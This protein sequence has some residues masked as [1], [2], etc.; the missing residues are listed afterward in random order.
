MIR[1]GAL[2][3][4]AGL[5]PS[6]QRWVSTSTDVRS[7]AL[8]FS[9][10]LRA[11]FLPK[12]SKMIYEDPETFEYESSSLLGDGVQ[13]IDFIA[14]PYDTQVGVIV[15]DVSVFVVFRGSDSAIDAVQNVK[16]SF[17]SSE[18][19]GYPVNVHSGFLENFGGVEGQ[20][21]KYVDGADGRQVYFAGHSLGGALAQI[22]ALGLGSSRVNTY[23]FGA[24]PV[25][26]QTWVDAMSSSGTGNR[27]ICFI[28]TD[29]AVP[30]VTEGVESNVFAAYMAALA[31]PLRLGDESDASKLRHGCKTVMINETSCLESTPVFDE[32]VAPD[33]I[34]DALDLHASAEYVRLIGEQCVDPSSGY[35]ACVSVNAAVDPSNETSNT[36]DVNETDET[37]SGDDGQLEDVTQSSSPSKWRYTLLAP[38][39]LWSMV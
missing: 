36:N 22:A 2:S 10:A 39:L 9:L 13:S 3:S 1:R 38:L 5:L 24:P 17:K 30:F 19:G 32:E 11:S 4:P 33:N 37:R 21:E 29:D 20:V 14:G 35:P 28:R 26:D 12:L 31:E 6:W 23:T 7:R 16:S 34:D 27:T 18:L 15:S 25:G 8:S